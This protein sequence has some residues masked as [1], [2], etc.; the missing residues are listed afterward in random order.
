MFV[1][2]IVPEVDYDE[3]YPGREAEV[4]LL[5]RSEVFKGKVQAV[6]GSSAVVEKDNLAAKEP[7][8]KERDARIRVQ[9]LPSALNTDFGNFCQVGRSAQVRISRHNLQLT[10]WIKG[11]WFNLF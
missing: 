3:I 11:L 10:Q 6:K 7:E 8:A 9:L 5:G 2:F 4:R 1:V